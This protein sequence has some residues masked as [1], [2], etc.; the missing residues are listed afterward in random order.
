MPSVLIHCIHCMC[1]LQQTSEITQQKESELQAAVAHYESLLQKR[2]QVI[3]EKD[4]KITELEF[5][6]M[7]S[8][9]PPVVN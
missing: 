9:E 5:G 3:V 2:D 8:S 6:M 4:I 1:I 7:P